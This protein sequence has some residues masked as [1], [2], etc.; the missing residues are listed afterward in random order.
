MATIECP[1][2]FEILEVE[3]PD[4]MHIAFSLVK[5][6]P[7]S[8]HGKIIKKNVKCQ[9]TDCKKSITIYWYAPL[10]YFARI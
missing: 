9:K 4:R 10:E 7:E 1:F 3:P 6:I 8:Y 5:P 2:C